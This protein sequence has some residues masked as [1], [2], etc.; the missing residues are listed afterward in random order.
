MRN[1]LSR[2]SC[3]TH[4][5]TKGIME[6]RQ[7]GDNHAHC[8]LRGK[9]KFMLEPEWVYRTALKDV[10]RHQETKWHLRVN[11][12]QFQYKSPGSR[13]ERQ[14]TVLES[15][16]LAAGHGNPRRLRYL[17]HQGAATSI[18]G[19]QANVCSA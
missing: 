14:Q 9:R 13:D 8:P 5:N 17:G 7:P 10:G 6:T 4:G 2:D 15:R 3:G 12:K 19:I 11:A 16:L 1:E 18:Q